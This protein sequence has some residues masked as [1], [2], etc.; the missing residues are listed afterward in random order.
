[1]ALI[2]CDVDGTSE[3]LK[4][5]LILITLKAHYL[6]ATVSTSLVRE[7]STVTNE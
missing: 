5:Y 7:T 4:Y 1:M 3:D 2:F 6:V